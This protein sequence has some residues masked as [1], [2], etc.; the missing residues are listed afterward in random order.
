MI[1]IDCSNAILASA[2]Q[3]SLDVLI[4]VSLDVLIVVSTKQISGCH[5]FDT[6]L[7]CVT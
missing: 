6:L 3:V 1:G 2:K 4:V 5:I 7:A